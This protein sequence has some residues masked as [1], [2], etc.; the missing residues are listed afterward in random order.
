MFFKQICIDCRSRIFDLSSHFQDGGHDVNTRIK[1]LLPGEWTRNVCRRLC[2]VLPV[3]DLYYIRTCL[4]N[5]SMF[6]YASGCKNF[7][8]NQHN[9][10]TRAICLVLGVR[11]GRLL[12]TSLLI[13]YIQRATFSSTTKTLITRQTWSMRMVRSLVLWWGRAHNPHR[14]LVK[15]VALHWNM[16]YDHSRSILIWFPTILAL[17]PSE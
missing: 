2:S 5:C 14:N 4:R 3:P 6:L 13:I 16:K 11:L 9:V 17:L 12:M 1:V 10:S 7:R 8:F 15:W